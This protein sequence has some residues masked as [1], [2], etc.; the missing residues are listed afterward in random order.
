MPTLAELKE[1]AKKH[2]I[3]IVGKKT[4]EEIEKAISRAEDI[5][6]MSPK[7]SPRGKPV[8]VLSPR[9]SPLKISQ[10][11]IDLPTVDKSKSVARR[12]LQLLR[13]AVGHRGVAAASIFMAPPP[14]IFAVPPPSIFAVPPAVPPSIFAVPPSMPA[15]IQ[16]IQT[17]PASSPLSYMS[18]TPFVPAVQEN[19]RGANCVY[20][21]KIPLLP[22]QKAVATHMINPNNRG[23]LLIHEA[24]TGKSITAVGSAACV[25]NNYPGVKTVV[26]APKSLIS[27]F[28]KEMVKYGIDENDTRFTFFTFE[29][30]SNAIANGIYK[31]DK[32]TFLIIDEAHNLKTKVSGLALRKKNDSPRKIGAPAAGKRAH[33]VIECAKRVFKILLLSATPLVNR[34]YDLANLIAMIDG[35][36]PVSESDF[37]RIMSSDTY[38][39]KYLYN[40]CSFYANTSR[41]EF[42]TV[43]TH[44]IELEMSWEF[45]K[46]YQLV[47][48]GMDEGIH[49]EI[50]GEGDLAVFYNGLRRAANNIGDDSVKIDWALARILQGNKTLVCSNFIDSGIAVLQK[51]LLNLKIPFVMVTGSMSAKARAQSVKDYNENKANVLLISKAGGEGLDLK[52]TRDVI[53]L[54]P[55]WNQ[56]TLIQFAARA[57]RYR[58]HIHLPKNEQNVRVF[59][60]YLKKPKG[61]RGKSIDQIMR[62]LQSK[63]QIAIDITYKYLYE[64]RVK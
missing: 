47:E 7:H 14:S 22:H 58:S 4:K 2:S 8:R 54:E 42:P 30:F 16:T 3:S 48:E 6:A 9:K 64:E 49:R 44:D 13:D 51:H 17:I 55:T 37:D 23:L 33:N 26:V 31:G 45:Y 40:K 5:R 1:Y 28:K 34:S 10:Q 29:N 56:A 24:G 11:N 15:T 59:N 41:R 50:F 20:M 35:A 39:K 63:K 27:N 21:G 53:I 43:T 38:R 12:S 32:N 36:D 62:A 61:I 25:M 57:A 52:G 46:I 19:P 60:L 18:P